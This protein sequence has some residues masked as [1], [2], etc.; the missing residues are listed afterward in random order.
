M[1][2][3]R[4]AEMRDIADAGAEAFESGFPIDDNPYDL[5]QDYVT[6]KRHWMWADGYANQRDLLE[7]AIEVVK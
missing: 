3:E 2:T 6:T 7:Q 5:G 4:E 1:M